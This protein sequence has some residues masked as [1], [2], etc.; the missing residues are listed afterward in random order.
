[1]SDYDIAEMTDF[2]RETYNR[3]LDFVKNKIVTPL[4]FD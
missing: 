2:H 3:F 4:S 1:M